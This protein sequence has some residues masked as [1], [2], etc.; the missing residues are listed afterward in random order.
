ML[1]IYQCMYCMYV[2]MFENYAYKCI[3]VLNLLKC[4]FIL[5][6]LIIFVCMCMYVCVCMYVLCICIMYVWIIICECGCRRSWRVWAAWIQ[7][8]W[9]SP[10]KSLRNIFENSGTYVTTFYTYI[11]TYIHTYSTYKASSHL[12]T[13]EAARSCRGNDNILSRE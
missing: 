10:M 8:S 11:H 13:Q 7:C 3:Q 2:C 5:V 4:V 1:W 6:P 12:Y 9:M